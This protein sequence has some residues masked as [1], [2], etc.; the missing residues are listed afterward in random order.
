[1]TSPTAPW[2]VLANS[3]LT[4]LSMWG[5]LIPLLLSGNTSALDTSPLISG[6]NFTS[7][8]YNILVHSQRGHGLSTLPSHSASP[9]SIP[10][11]ATDIA[12]TLQSLKIPLPVH[13]VVGVS[14]GGAAALALAGLFECGPSSNVPRLTK[15]IVACDTAPRTPAGN[16]SAWEERIALVH[17]SGTGGET[18]GMQPLAQVTVPR[19]FPTGS[20]CNPTSSPRPERWQW[21]HEMIT[22]TPVHGFAAGARG[23][24]SYD[25]YNLRRSGDDSKLGVLE[26]DV[27]HVLLLAGQLDG[28][29]KVGSGMRTLAAEWE[30]ARKARSSSIQRSAVRY[31]EIPS[32]GHLPMID[33]PENFWAVLSPFLASF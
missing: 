12:A 15:S 3:L 7:R 14:Q 6:S 2:I 19:W 22:R 31:E 8:S 26:S 20:S 11:L 5:Y 27:Q 13:S 28:A 10:S 32:A 16:Q 33:S 4:D 29:G 17:G 9:T 24:G 23:L 21:V 30:A 18:A 25:T 1:M